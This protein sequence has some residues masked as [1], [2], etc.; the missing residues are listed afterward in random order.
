MLTEAQGRQGKGVGR[1]EVVGEKRSIETYQV[2]SLCAK[3]GEEA[4]QR[5]IGNSSDLTILW[6]PF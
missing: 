2:H 1:A 6:I 4:L 5:S 3:E